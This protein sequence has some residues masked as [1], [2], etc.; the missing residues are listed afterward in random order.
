MDTPDTLLL[1]HRNLRLPLF[2]GLL[3]LALTG[4]LWHHENEAAQA[5]LQTDFD[6]AVR[7][8]VSRIRERVA[9]YEQMLRAAR[10]LFDASDSVT[11]KI[12]STSS[13]R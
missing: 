2:V 5:R 9:S 12:S 3:S 7:Q 6:F 13:A 10:G 1:R 8:S 11:A 4:W